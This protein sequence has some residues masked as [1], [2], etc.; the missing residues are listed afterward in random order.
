MDPVVSPDCCP[1]SH[2][3]TLS[4]SS[5]WTSYLLPRSFTAAPLGVGPLKSGSDVFSVKT[6]EGSGGEM[7]WRVI[8][9]LVILQRPH[10]CKVQEGL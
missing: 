6:H 5:L 8:V 10:T 1:S 4:G 7:A 9:K 3:Q 2:L